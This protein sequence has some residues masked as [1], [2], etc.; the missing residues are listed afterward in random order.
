M[1]VKFTYVTRF[2]SV[3]QGEILSHV[4]LIFPSYQIRPTLT[5]KCA[6]IKFIPATSGVFLD[7]VICHTVVRLPT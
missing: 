2:Y 3:D 4:M 7:Q 1:D 6:R 5:N